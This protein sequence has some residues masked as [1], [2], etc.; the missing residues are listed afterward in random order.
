MRTAKKIELVKNPKMVIPK[1]NLFKDDN[2]VDRVSLDEWTLPSDKSF[3]DFLRQFDDATRSQ[4]REPLKLWNSRENKY[5]DI[6]AYSHQKFVSD[7][8]NDNSPY[9]GLLLY[10]GLGSG[11]SGASIMI[12]EGFKN[13][14]IVIMLPASLRNNYERELATFADIG[15]KKNYNWK[16]VNLSKI[17]DSRLD[18]VKEL[19]VGK[20]LDP[21][22][23]AKIMQHNNSKS[24][25]KGIWMINYSNNPPP[26]FDTLDEKSQKQL[27]DQ[28]KIMFD[29]RFTILNYNSGQYTI[30]NIFERLLPNYSALHIK[31]FGNK[32]KSQLSNK[33]RTTLLNYVYNPENAVPNPFDD[34][35]L[36]IDEIHNL[37]ASMVGSGFNGPK[38]YEL[39]MRAK[40][41]KVV[42][43]SGTPV[44]NY[45]FELGLMMNMLRGLIRS[46][47]IPLKHPSGI[48]NAG[49]IESSLRNVKQ[50]D[51]FKVNVRNKS[52]DVTRIPIGF[53][54][55]P[56]GN[57]KVIKS[58]LNNDTN[59]IFFI[60]LIIQ[61]LSKQGYQQ[62]GD[63]DVNYYSMFPDLLVNRSSQESMIG[64]SNE[65]DMSKELFNNFYIDSE[66]FLLKN[67]VTFKNRITGLVSFYNEI[68]GKDE[69]TGADIFP[70]LEFAS[71]DETHAYMSNFQF[72]EYAAKR[73]IERELEQL[74]KRRGGVNQKAMIESVTENVPNLFR[75]F[76]R[77]K[78]L[79][80]FPPTIERP[81][82]PKKD[83]LIKDSILT[84]A[85]RDKIDKI[86]DQLKV[87]MQGSHEGRSDKLAEYLSTLSTDD[88]NIA[89]ELLGKLYS[90]NPGEFKDK[91][92]WLK[93]YKFND[94]NALN[95]DVNVTSDESEQTYR[96]ICLRAIDQLT[97]NNLTIEGEGINL[98]DLSPKYALMLKN[99]HN[100][101]GL[102]FGYSQ[103]RSVEGIEIFARILIQHG[104]S[105]L[106]TSL[107][108]KE[109][110]IERDDTIEK[111]V[112]VRYEVEKDTW[113]TYLVE[114]V[115]GTKVRLS[116]IDEPVDL[117]KVYR[118][119]FALWT[120]TESV[121]ERS[122]ILDIYRGLTNKYGQDCL[123]L[124]TTQSGAEGISLAYV[125][126]VHVMEPYWNN[127]RIE[128]VIGRARRIKSH[129]LLPEDQRNVKVYQYIIKLTEAQKNGV[130]LS[131]MDSDE[132]LLL[133]ESKDSGFDKDE[134]PESAE[135]SKAFEIYAQKLSSEIAQNDEGLTSDEVLAEISKNKKRILDSFLTLMKE[136]AVDCNFNKRD[137]IMSNRSLESLKCNDI[138]I[139]EGNV[140][141]DIWSDELDS[142]STTSVTESEKIKKIKTKK[143]IMTQTIKGKQ[144]KT[145]MNLPP[146]LSD[147][148]P[149]E[150][151]RQLPVG[152]KIFDYYIYYDLYH[153]EKSGGFKSL[154]KIGEII[155]KDG[156]NKIRLIPQFLEKIEDYSEIHDCMLEKQ[157]EGIVMPDSGEFEIIQ[158]A[159]IIKDCH[160]KKEKWICEFC[161]EERTGPMC[162]ECEISRAESESYQVKSSATTTS[163][164]TT[165]TFMDLTSDE[166]SDED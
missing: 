5:V 36:V 10:H 31:L 37:T 162:E 125:R 139:G 159:E 40:N 121:E 75:V 143:L 57:G 150:A 142:K 2:T 69:A 99:I 24:Y 80:V 23:F 157:K 83:E 163:T 78:G 70:E 103:F 148:S 79:F 14:R 17:A 43:L 51:R 93:S 90:D 20:G 106:K 136:S 16:F 122:K 54:K 133:Q 29:H 74:N 145:F 96:D 76:S 86:A 55:S 94:T 146:E 164:K 105:Q 46:F 53:I 107:R 112:R 27:L 151:I 45:A 154:F 88:S 111:D 128:Q 77:Q 160:R 85:S 118:A 1:M 116:G 131:D 32:K 18:E 62:N 38:L 100:T 123:M 127:V 33:D 153:K 52:I 6:G 61:E 119:S 120:G 68:S 8:M 28:I 9:R 97:K 98:M 149:A 161:E 101:P 156:A 109:V 115:E 135:I 134:Y 59:D 95:L 25:P 71:E 84:T 166:E 63:Y 44:I 58:E 4:E 140:T 117:D 26:N 60:G 114:E 138:I 11:K 13:R 3:P 7:F 87:I 137:N 89:D 110:D 72:I 126:Q 132:L 30:T 12:T 130:W 92:A 50:I 102:V 39:I 15:Y 49:Q 165:V 129:V 158:Y 35:V 144:I 73:K 152:H 81:M 104:Y 47:R 34:K 113:R 64:N 48:F 82:P 67:T 21:M 66:K 141:Y 22:V 65:R 41:L 147:A 155:N 56:S 91:E 19:L 42:L 124:F 108:G